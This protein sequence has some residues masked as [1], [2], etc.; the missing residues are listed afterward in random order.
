MQTHDIQLDINGLLFIVGKSKYRGKEKFQRNAGVNKMC[1][2]AK[3][4]L[5][6]LEKIT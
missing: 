6:G 4:K 5:K 1:R 2:S 3:G